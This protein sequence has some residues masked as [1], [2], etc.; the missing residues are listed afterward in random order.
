TFMVPPDFPSDAGHTGGAL[1]SR[2]R[3]ASMAP[4]PAA[5]A[6]RVRRGLVRLG[7]EHVADREDQVARAAIA[8]G[9]DMARAEPIEDRDPHAQERHAEPL[10][11]LA[12]VRMR[13]QQ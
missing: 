3:R 2:N 6:P 8:D 11:H 1:M 10:G 9:D 12:P 7:H 13:D 5:D 4:L